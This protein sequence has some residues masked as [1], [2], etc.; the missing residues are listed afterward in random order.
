MIIYLCHFNTSFMNKYAYT[1]IVG[2]VVV[3]SKFKQIFHEFS[4]YKKKKNSINYLND[5]ML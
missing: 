5:K 1:S 4:R 2:F 3:N